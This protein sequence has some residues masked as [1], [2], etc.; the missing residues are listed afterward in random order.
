MLAV[1]QVFHKRCE[2]I[3]GGLENSRPTRYEGKMSDGKHWC[4]PEVV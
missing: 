3:G 2:V 4:E 1:S